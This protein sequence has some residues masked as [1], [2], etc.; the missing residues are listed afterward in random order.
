M[1]REPAKYHFFSSINF[2][3]LWNFLTYI[4]NFR[5]LKCGFHKSSAE[6]GKISETIKMVEFLICGLIQYLVYH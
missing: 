5:F 1:F 3:E 2:P 6:L 4:L